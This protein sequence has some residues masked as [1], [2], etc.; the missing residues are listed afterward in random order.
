MLCMAPNVAVRVRRMSSQ[1][2]AD[3]GL[4]RIGVRYKVAMQHTSSC[5]SVHVL[6]HIPST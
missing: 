6:K 5:E 3:L 4:G 1:E 2:S